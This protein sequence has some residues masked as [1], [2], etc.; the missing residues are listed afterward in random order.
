MMR[1]F[2]QNI[3]TTLIKDTDI[4]KDFSTCSQAENL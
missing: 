1:K 2:T 4:L 3:N